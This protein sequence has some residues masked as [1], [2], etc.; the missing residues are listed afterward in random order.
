M[1][2]RFT[3]WRRGQQAYEVVQTQFEKL[4]KYKENILYSVIFKLYLQ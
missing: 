3:L 4:C 2:L 1:F